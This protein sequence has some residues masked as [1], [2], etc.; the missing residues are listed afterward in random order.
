MQGRLSSWAPW[1]PPMRGP[2]LFRTAADRPAGLGGP[3]GTGTN[4]RHFQPGPSA[5][6]GHEP[7]SPDSRRCATRPVIA[8]ARPVNRGDADQDTRPRGQRR[9][10]GSDVPGRDTDHG[11]R[12]PPGHTLNEALGQGFDARSTAPQAV[13]S[14]ALRLQEASES[15]MRDE[16]RRACA[17]PACQPGSSTEASSARTAAMP[18][19]HM[20][21]IIMIPC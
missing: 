7:G 15:P 9:R 13:M 5:R 4:F 11:E 10:A 18:S 20:Y 14:S 16:V 12:R 1:G 6:P 21:R 19:C 17:R 8:P 2:V 3:W